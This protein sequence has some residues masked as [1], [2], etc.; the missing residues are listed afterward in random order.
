MSSV[1]L[2]TV[3]LLLAG[4][5]GGGNAQQQQTFLV[6]IAGRV[7][8]ANTHVAV[9]DASIAI[10]AYPVVTSGADGTF[11]V[12]DVQPAANILFQVTHADYQALVGSLTLDA[13]ARTW[14]LTV[15]AQVAGQGGLL[16][17]SAGHL[18]VPSLG[19]AGC[20]VVNLTHTGGDGGDDLPPP[21]PVWP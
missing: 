8:N 20:M 6:T 12:P 3:V 14:A 1:L 2:V 4:C 13:T 19:E 21:P 16:E 10:G 17:V 15:G 7:A 5:G 9:A 18:S 11:S